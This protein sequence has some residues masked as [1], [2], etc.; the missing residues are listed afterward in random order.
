MKNK[1]FK[2]IVD[3]YTMSN[4]TKGLHFLNI[5]NFN[6][7][8]DLIELVKE[9][10]IQ[11]LHINDVMNPFVRNYNINKSEE[12]QIK[13]LKE[14]IEECILYPSENVDIDLRHDKEN[15]YS[16]KMRGGSGGKDLIYFEQDVLKKYI[17]NQN[18]L[19]QNSGFN[20]YIKMDEEAVKKGL[21]FISIKH[22]APC[23]EINGEKRA[24]GVTLNEL[25]N[26]PSKEQMYWHSF[27][28]EDQEKWVANE[29]FTKA[30]LI[31]GWLEKE[32]IYNDILSKL[33]LIN[34]FC[35]NLNH[36]PLFKKDFR[37]SWPADFYPI[38]SPTNKNFN[39]FLLV[40][41]NMLPEN[42]NKDFFKK[43]ELL[44][45]PLLLKRKDGSH[46]GT[47]QLLEDFLYEVYPH[48]E[49]MI[50]RILDPIY[51]LRNKRNPSAHKVQETKTD[52]DFYQQQED[53]VYDIWDS[54]CNL[55]TAL[56][57]HPKNR[58]KLSEEKFYPVTF[59]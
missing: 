43:C 51:E 37:D 53:I 12:K 32:W 44:N 40:F 22:C 11:V 10:K 18:Y 3:C 52:L 14:N 17:E 28:F 29:G 55:I 58:K 25:S 8:E 6:K 47:I 46:K 4:Q 5:K 7:V 20:I 41:N 42:L 15:P 21:E 31:G 57:N 59:Y 30:I 9:N 26:L 38:L 56:G 54:L 35:L 23:K 45:E 24:F 34:E 50:K 1:I 33:T 27:E 49:D 13:D 48:E 16:Y 2:E 39:Q 19:I 36:P